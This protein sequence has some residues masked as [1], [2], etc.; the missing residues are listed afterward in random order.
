MNRAYYLWLLV[1]IGVLSTGGQAMAG[2]LALPDLTQLNYKDRGLA[3]KAWPKIKKTLPGLDAYAQDLQVIEVKKSDG[4]PGIVF[5]ILVADPPKIIPTAF[6]ARG[7]HC[8]LDVDTKAK[9]VT[10]PKRA[11]MSVALQINAFDPA[12]AASLHGGPLVL[13]LH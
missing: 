10:I 1:M 11:C 12:L 7:H 4:G 2:G 9:K 5:H 13:D 3:K 6:L 8:Y